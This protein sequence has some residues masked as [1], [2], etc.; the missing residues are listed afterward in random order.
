MKIKL[1][2]AQQ[3]VRRKNLKIEYQEK[4][5]I[6]CELKLAGCWKDNALSFAHKDKRWKYIRRPLE[7]WTFKETILACVPCHQIIEGNREL[8]E[9]F[10]KRL[11]NN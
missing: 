11:R 7:L 9:K 1:T 10:F 6:T 4:G 5:I 2:N 3:E 8:T